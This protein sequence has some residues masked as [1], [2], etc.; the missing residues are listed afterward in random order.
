LSVWYFSNLF[1]NDLDKIC[2]LNES[3]D[4]VTDIDIEYDHMECEVP[5]VIG[6]HVPV[7][8]SNPRNNSVPYMNRELRKGI[9]NKQVR[10]NK[11]EKYHTDK[12]WEK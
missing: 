1:V 10:R 9:Y 8:H 2:L 3:C 12:T 5:K 7:K 11:F 6:K 4:N